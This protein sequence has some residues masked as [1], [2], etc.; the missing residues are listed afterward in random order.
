MDFSTGAPNFT[1]PNWSAIVKSAGAQRECG[2]R[3]DSWGVSWQF[4]PRALI[5]AITDPDPATAKHCFD[6][7]LQM[8]KVD[9]AMI[10]KARLG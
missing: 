6:A 8:Q 2:W 7:M 1:R 3:K 4:T 9:F 5:A 10:E